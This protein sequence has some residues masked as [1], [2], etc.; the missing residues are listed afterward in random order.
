MATNTHRIDT[1]DEFVAHFD[2]EGGAGFVAAH[3]DGT[4]ETEDAISNAT[5]TTIRCIPL[6]PLLASDGEPGVCVFSGKP[7]TQRVIFAKAY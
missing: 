6:E 4:Q 1:W 7:S 3:W 5:K 2:G